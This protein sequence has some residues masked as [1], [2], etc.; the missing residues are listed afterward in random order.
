MTDTNSATAAFVLKEAEAAGYAFASN[1]IELVTKEPA[2]IPR[3]SRRSFDR[4][5]FE[6]RIAIMAL[7][8]DTYPAC[9]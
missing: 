6:H 8:V 7:I 3:E 4:A 5:I 2:G 1:G 9:R